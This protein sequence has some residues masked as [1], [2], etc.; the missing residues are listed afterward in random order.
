M[1]MLDHVQDRP[2]HPGNP[3]VPIRR[4]VR[5]VAG[6]A[7]VVLAAACSGGT[8]APTPPPTAP[9]PTPTAGPATAAAMA[10]YGEF[11]RLSES[12]F[13]A[14]SAKDWQTEMSKVARG[15]ALT[16]VM[17]E[18]RNY[19]SVP[20]HLEGTISNSPGSDPAVSP[21][22]DR[23]AVLDC[24]DISDSRVV[25][26]RGGGDVLNDVENQVPRYRYRAQ[27]VK[28][29]TGGWLVETT[30]PALAESC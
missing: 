22:A 28:D 14:P 17:V 10:A 15:Q 20:A 6:L 23:V 1:V 3:G 7:A 26:D 11:W 16:D 19:A 24:V 27:V 21:S 30:A 18:I 8:P 9:A 12:A 25:A 5:L 13:A 29:S 2:V 4:V